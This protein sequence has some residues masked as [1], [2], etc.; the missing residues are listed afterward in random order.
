V[1]V[2]GGKAYDGIR[3]VCTK[4]TEAAEAIAGRTAGDTA[5][6]NS[7]SGLAAVTVQEAIDELAAR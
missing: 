1:A 6:D 2:E 3:E 5:Y 7:S 4:I